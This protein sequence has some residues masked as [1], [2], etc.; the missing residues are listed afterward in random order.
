[1]WSSSASSAR[2]RGSSSHSAQF[3]VNKETDICGCGHRLITRTSLTRKN[4]GRRFKACPGTNCH[5]VFFWIDDEI[6]PR[7][8]LIIR[9]LEEQGHVLER[10]MM[11][12]KNRYQT[13]VCVGALPWIIVLMCLVSY[14]LNKLGAIESPG[15]KLSLG[16][17]H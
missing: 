14:C 4:P 7:T 5:N 12:Y 6:P 10:R 1:M 2:N 9:D 17:M 3:T 8:V 16:Y 15:C 13:M 11:H